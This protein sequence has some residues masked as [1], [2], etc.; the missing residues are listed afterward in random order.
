MEYNVKLPLKRFL[1][2]L[3]V[4]KQEI[5]SI[6]VY[7]IFNGLV[8]LSLPLGVQAIINLIS[9]GQVSTSWIVLVTIVVL[10]VALNGGMQIMQ[11]T[12]SENIQ[13]KL[14][15]RSAFD[16]AYR[17]PRIKLKAFDDEYAP[18]L[19]NRFFDTLTVQKGLSKILLDF[20]SAILQVVFGLILLSIYHSYFILY[21][22]T[23]LIVVFIIFRYTAKKGLITSLKESTY[24]YKVA[25]W[26]EELARTQDTF[27]MAPDSSLPLGK[28]DEA[29]SGYLKYR[30][31]HFKTLVI[32]FISL[33][34]FKVVMTAGLL[35]IGGLLV[36]GQKMNIGQFVAAEIIILMIITSI[37]KIM[38]IIETIYDVL[39][40]VEKMGSIADMPLDCEEGENI[41]ISKTKAFDIKVSDLSYSFSEVEGTEVIKNINVDIKAG[42]N[43]CIAGYHGSGKSIL[44]KHLGGLYDNYSGRILF[45]GVSLKNWKKGE[46]RCQIG[47]CLSKE[48]IFA[49]SI[50][51]N[52]TL[53]KP[54]VGKLEVVKVAKVLGIASFIE[55]QKNSYETLLIAE[56]K[57]LP[58]SVRLKIILARS[59]VAKSQL[60]LLGDLFNQ[61]G[62]TDKEK[63]LNYIMSQDATCIA[64][65]NDPVVADCFDRV[66]VLNQGEL[67]A[68]NHHSKLKH[69]GWYNNVFQ[70]N[71]RC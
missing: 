17:I 55:T 54:G 37:E 34:S 66:L 24:K 5:F 49:G 40:S 13:Q 42:E 12:I 20:S 62:K 16:F 39:T 53:G 52:I 46:L 69:L 64:T 51:D 23:F 9:G 67:I 28:T 38:Q 30:K 2:L 22:I 56:G 61:L 41:D 10:G 50:M 71:N 3:K 70:T 31:S 14:F 35:I 7:A 6:Y 32:Q 60:I 26:L 45:N 63:F 36:I 43:I 29:V 18:E 19:T 58:K 21:S 11:M 1:N 59:I 4:E 47:S 15:A 48:E 65:S 27:K 8:S 33:V 57:N 25:H 44:I 68:D